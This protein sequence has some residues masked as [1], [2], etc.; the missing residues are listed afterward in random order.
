MSD[1]SH[2]TRDEFQVLWSALPLAAPVTADLIARRAADLAAWERRRGISVAVIIAVGVGQTAT[3]F[4]FRTWPLA[5]WE[6]AGLAYLVAFSVALL[7]IALRG[8]GRPAAAPEGTECVRVYRSLLERERDANRGQTLAVRALLVFGLLGHSAF[9]ALNYVPAMVW[10]IAI[11]A[12]AAAGMVWR[13]G[14]V[15]A[16][17]FQ[18][19]IDAVDTSQRA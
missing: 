4:M 8:R 18:M 17:L 10:P 9:I 6:W 5:L 14:Q 12:L 7:W 15:R 19:H 16:R 11:V 13:R 2:A 3:V 1:N